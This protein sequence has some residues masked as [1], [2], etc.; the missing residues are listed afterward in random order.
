MLAIYLKLAIVGFLLIGAY[1]EVVVKGTLVNRSIRHY[2]GLKFFVEYSG[3]TT[4]K[5]GIAEM[6]YDEEIPECD[7]REFTPKRFF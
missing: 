1:Q 5:G 4:I 3:E 7:Y 6:P 2:F